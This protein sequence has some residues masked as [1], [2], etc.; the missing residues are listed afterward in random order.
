VVGKS[1]S[2]EQTSDLMRRLAALHP[3]LELCNISFKQG[4]LRRACGVTSPNDQQRFAL[5]CGV[6]DPDDVA[7]Q[8]RSSGINLVKVFKNPDHSSFAIRKVLAESSSFTSIVT[9]EKDWA[10]DQESFESLGIPVYVVPLD[11]EWVQ[12]PP[13]FL[14][15]NSI[16]LEH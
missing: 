10:R 13:K 6:A 3:T 14:Q 15:K 5:V 16:I 7:N 12:G 9:T 2:H 1:A 8:L 4:P 11:L